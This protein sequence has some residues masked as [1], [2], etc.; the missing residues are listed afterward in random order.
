M[1]VERLAGAAAAAADGV[2]AAGDLFFCC[3]V[4]PVPELGSR[5][6]RIWKSVGSEFKYACGGKKGMFIY[7]L[8]MCEYILIR[9]ILS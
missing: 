6:E 8:T 9:D 4:G 5:A 1:G 3:C 2:H 7:S